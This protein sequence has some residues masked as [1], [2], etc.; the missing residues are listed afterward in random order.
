MKDTASWG[1]YLAPNSPKGQ[2]L[3]YLLGVLAISYM[4]SQPN[5]VKAISAQVLDYNSASL[6]LHR[7]LGFQETGMLK[8]HFAVADKTYDVVEFELSADNFLY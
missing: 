3:G 1:F 7:K 6:A 4:F 5:P 8:Q 2:G